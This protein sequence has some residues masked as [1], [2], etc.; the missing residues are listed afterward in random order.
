MNVILAIHQFNRNIR[1]SV[2]LN[3]TNTRMF[4][5]LVPL[6]ELNCVRAILSLENHKFRSIINSIVIFH[7]I[8]SLMRDILTSFKLIN[9]KNRIV[10]FGQ[11]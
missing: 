8:V 10:L 7:F 6:I 2:P 3:F 11:K 1:L 5:A 9:L 4:D